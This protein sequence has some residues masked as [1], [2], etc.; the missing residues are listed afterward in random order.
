[1]HYRVTIFLLYY[2]C[3][4]KMHR[5]AWWFCACKCADKWRRSWE[6][7]ISRMITSRRDVPAER[8]LPRTEKTLGVI[9]AMSVQRD[10]AGRCCS[11]AFRVF[12]SCGV[13]ACIFTDVIRM[14]VSRLN[15]LPRSINPGNVFCLHDDEPARKMRRKHESHF[16]LT[17]E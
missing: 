15:S 1:V 3:L 8:L 9:N 16:Y 2:A 14:S 5:T 6:E 4:Y 7:I 13:R 17:F 12:H 10:P 11:A